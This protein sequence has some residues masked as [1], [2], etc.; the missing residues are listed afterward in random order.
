MTALLAKPRR[1]W[2]I[3][4]AIVVVL[5]IIATVVY[6]V[7]ARATTTKIT[8]YF[9]ST[10]GLYGGDD[11]RILG[12]KIGNVDSIE[13][14]PESSKVTMSVDSSYKI[15]ADAK[16][17]IIAQS[18]V[19]ARFVQLAPVYTGGPTMA[20]GAVIPLQRTAV[21]VEWDD[22]KKELTKL[23]TALGP[24]G[25]EEQGSFGRF[26]NT[27]AA[28]LDGN[29]ERLRA[30]LH[31]LSHTLTILSDGRTDLFGTIRNLEE[32]VSAL[33]NSNEQI[34]QF[35]GRLASVSEVLASSSDELGR[36]L[37]DLDVALGNVQRFVADN[38]AKLGEAVSRLGDATQVLVDKRPELEQ[39]LHIAPTA[40]AN[41]YQIYK[42]AQGTL[43]GAI[44][45]SNFAN[46]V[47]FLCG[48]IEGLQANDSDK[49]ANLCVQYLA[50]ILNSLI[51]NYPPLLTNPASGVA[52]FPNQIEYSPPSLSSRAPV[53]A[54]P[55]PA[56]PAAPPMPKDLG[57]LLLP[58]GGR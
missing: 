33:S 27:A 16:A 39:V 41:F 25:S 55:V 45:M 52:A 13:P 35:G 42:P 43:T 12:V 38:R 34:V 22:I 17:V 36:A 2:V 51:M 11:V 6:L 23:S 50:P 4:G 18:L 28:N 3:L 20:D 40:L 5:A 26:V 31:E 49:S 44:S 15:P 56:P 29:G 19:S 47:N 9:S 57:A 8:A 7:V 14:Q 32:F 48:S 54:T 1:K 24:Q 46:P 58:G 30:T 10:T 21:P 53:G 37:D